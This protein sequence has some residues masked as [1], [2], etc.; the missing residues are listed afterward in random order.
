LA[1]APAPTPAGPAAVRSASAEPPSEPPAD[2]SSPNSAAAAK[3]RPERRAKQDTTKRTSK[4][5]ASGTDLAKRY[6]GKPALATLSGEASYYADSLAGNPTAS[7]EPYRPHLHSAAHRKLPF[8]TVVRVVR[9][10]TGATTYAVVNDRGP[11]GGRGRIIDLSRAAAKD[12]DMIRA[13]VVRVRV[14]V[15][16]RP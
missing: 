10:D 4:A 16:E 15:L 1:C 5:G 3:K 12:L 11:F 7:G 6:E 2:S 14:E 13:G 8:G 9:K